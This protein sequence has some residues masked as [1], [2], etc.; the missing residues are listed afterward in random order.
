MSLTYQA[1]VCFQNAGDTASFTV[2]GSLPLT[3]PVLLR[4][5]HVGRKCRIEADTMVITVALAAPVTLDTFPA[6]SGSSRAAV[7]AWISPR[8]RSPASAHR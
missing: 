7:R 5:P 8:P 2:V 1:A 6:C 3:P 4:D